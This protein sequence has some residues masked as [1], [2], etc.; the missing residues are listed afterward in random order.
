MGGWNIFYGLLNFAILAEV[1]YFAGRKI[2]VRMF[3]SRRDK[4]AGD[5]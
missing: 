2:V 1:L 5:L 3:T 4:I